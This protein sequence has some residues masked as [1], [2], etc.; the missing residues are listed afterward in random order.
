MGEANDIQ[1]L[2]HY[3]ELVV[4]AN[5]YF[6]MDRNIR[7]FIAT[8]RSGTERTTSRT[9]DNGWDEYIIHIRA[10]YARN[11]R[12]LCFFE[13]LVPKISVYV[14]SNIAC[15]TSSIVPF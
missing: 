12:F 8:S 9:G 15:R 7:E 3:D 2:V 6:N 11:P 13:I 14:S 10:S 1:L 5:N 4:N